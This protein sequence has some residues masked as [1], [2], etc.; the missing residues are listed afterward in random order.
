[1][2]GVGE[3]YTLPLVARY[4]DVWN[5]PTY[6]LGELEHKV[7]VL[8]SLCE[9]IDRDP[10]SIVLSVEA[11]MAL[12]PDDASLPAVR[13]LAEKRFGIPAFGLAEG[14]LV[15]TPSAIVDRLHELQGLGF[16]QI[17]LFTHDRGSDQT[18]ELLASEV[19]AQL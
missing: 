5:V 13:A 6:A 17:V 8:R 19:I 7:S 1:V 14:G 10:S 4:A 11:V 3:K 18:L 2:G 12:A 9:E 15:G 16:G